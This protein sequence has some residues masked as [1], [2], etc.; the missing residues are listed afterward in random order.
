VFSFIPESP[1]VLWEP[2]RRV[3]EGRKQVTVKANAIC[4]DAVYFISFLSV[5]EFHDKSSQKPCQ[6]PGVAFA[7]GLSSEKPPPSLPG[8]CSLHRSGK[9]LLQDAERGLNAGK[10][11]LASGCKIPA[12]ARFFFLVE[13]ATKFKFSTRFL[14]KNDIERSH[15]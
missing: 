3:A 10:A 5:F 15:L 2:A 1:E 14:E 4:S 7:T 6:S 13:S 12:C 11:K 9:D 8:S